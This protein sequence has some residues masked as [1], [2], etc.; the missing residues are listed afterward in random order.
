MKLLAAV[1]LIA[2]V[3]VAFPAVAEQEMQRGRDNAPGRMRGGMHQF[4]PVQ[5]RPHISKDVAEQR[6]SSDAP[7]VQQGP[8]QRM[9]PGQ[10]TGRERL[11]PE[12]RRQLRRDIN[13]AGNN[14]YRHS[15]TE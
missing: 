11:T 9:E 1:L 5:N 3:G 15:R 12:E 13:A 2:V 7:L 6:P 10:T 14:I 4:M 8:E